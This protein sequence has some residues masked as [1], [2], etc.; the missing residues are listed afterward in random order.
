MTGLILAGASSTIS[1]VVGSAEEIR[2]VYSQ[3]LSAGRNGTDQQRKALDDINSILPGLPAM[4]GLLAPALRPASE[5]EIAAFLAQLLKAFPNAGKEE[6]SAFGRLL[7]EDV[8]DQKPS[9][10][11][12]EA[13]CRQVRQTSKFLPSISEV[14]EAVREAEAVLQASLTR[15]SELPKIAEEFEVQIQEAERMA[16]L[17][18]NRGKDQR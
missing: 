6:A 9:M 8:I 11:A 3:A 10:G 14:L 18:A 7:L 16:H 17:K 13:G 5:Q 4:R 12:M 1:K 2:R 15:A